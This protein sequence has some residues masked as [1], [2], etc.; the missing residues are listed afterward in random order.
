[1]EN[2]DIVALDKR[3]N[4]DDTLLIIENKVNNYSISKPM[5]AK[6]LS[7]LFEWRYAWIYNDYDKYI[8]FY[9]PDFV[10]Y[11]KMSFDYFK[12]YKNRIFN[13]SERKNIIF[14]NINIIK[15]PNS[16]NIYQISFYEEYQSQSFTFEGD[17]ILMVKVD[18][19]FKIGIFTEK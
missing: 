18:N 15:Y 8:S 16:E 5:V 4:I 3:I 12:R 17:K 13:K 9:S 19:S 1:M 7:Q 11:D 6:I 2:S 10:R 14:K